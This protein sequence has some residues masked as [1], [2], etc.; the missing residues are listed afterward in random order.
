M[1]AT[2]GTREI[3]GILHRA[4]ND[5]FVKEIASFISEHKPTV[6]TVAGTALGA[7]GG[8]LLAKPGK[9]KAG[10]KKGAMIGALSGLS[11]GTLADIAVEFAK[12]ARE[13]AK[14]AEDRKTADA[15]TRMR[16]GVPAA[17]AAA[18]KAAS[19][20][21]MTPAQIEKT[22]DQSAS[23]IMGGPS[24]SDRG[25]NP[26]PLTPTPPPPKNRNRQGAGA[27]ASNKKPPSKNSGTNTRDPKNNPASK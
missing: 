25:G 23:S 2:F 20:S 16:V 18:G 15:E 7:G 12:M 9:R 27:T 17:E 5:G 19:P 3:A 26:A 14:A 11:A 1:P 8:A 4:E 22:S 24:N 10:A 13:A 21:S 6:G